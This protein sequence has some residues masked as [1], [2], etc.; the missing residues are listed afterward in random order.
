MIN[1]IPFRK[2]CTG[3]PEGMHL[4][5]EKCALCKRNIHQ[6]CHSSGDFCCNMPWLTYSAQ[7]D[8]TLTIQDKI[9]H[10]LKVM[11]QR[12][13][14]FTKGIYFFVKYLLCFF[15]SIKLRHHILS[16]FQI[17]S[18]V[19]PHILFS[20]VTVNPPFLP[21]EPCSVHPISQHPGLDVFP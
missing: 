8:F 10:N 18:T 2:A 13:P 19:P 21:A 5:S 16:L 9:L 15:D 4:I 1:C 14:G 6:T 7:N 20:G 17:F 3:L 11:S 12:I